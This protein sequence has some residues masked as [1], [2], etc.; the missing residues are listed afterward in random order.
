[1]NKS[2]SRGWQRESSDSDMDVV[3]GKGDGEEDC[4]RGDSK[5]VTVKQGDRWWGTGK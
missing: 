1:M 4:V 2:S 3:P 5:E